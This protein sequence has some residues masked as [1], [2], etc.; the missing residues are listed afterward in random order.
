MIER[1]FLKNHPKIIP[2]NSVWELTLWYKIEIHQT[3]DHKMIKR[4]Q[5]LL[6][7]Q[8]KMAVG[9]IYQQ[10]SHRP[11]LVQLIINH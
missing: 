9:E 2:K 11:W 1:E 4:F 7:V 6:L 8:G 5:A 10:Y 3:W